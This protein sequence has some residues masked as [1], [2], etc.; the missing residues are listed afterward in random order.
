MV[1]SKLF[2]FPTL[3]NPLLEL[4]LAENAKLLE[5]PLPSLLQHTCGIIPGWGEYCQFLDNLS[6][7]VS[8]LL[9]KRKSGALSHGSLISLPN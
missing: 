5:V 1:S 7:Q 3:G 8:Q 6:L 9:T 2:A 4:L